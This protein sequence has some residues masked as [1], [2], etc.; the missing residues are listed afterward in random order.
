MKR[1]YVIMESPIFTDSIEHIPCDVV[2]SMDRA[3]EMCAELHEEH[4]DRY[5]YWVEL[6]SR[7]LDP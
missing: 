3:E 6:I 7:E 2:L 4:D 5:Y 1:V